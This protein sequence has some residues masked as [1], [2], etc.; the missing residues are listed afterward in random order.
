MRQWTKARVLV[1]S[2]VYAI[3]AAVVM[4][5]MDLARLRS[6]TDAAKLPQGIG[7]SD[8]FIVGIDIPSWQFLVV[9]LPPIALLIYWRIGRSKHSDLHK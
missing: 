8:D 7:P 1:A 2:V 5:R 9:L 6:A 3:V 4:V